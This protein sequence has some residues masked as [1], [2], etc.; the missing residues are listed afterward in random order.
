MEETMRR[1]AEALERVE[2]I[3]TDN[4]KTTQQYHQLR[5]DLSKI[6]KEALLE[7]P[8]WKNELNAEKLAAY[9]LPSMLGKLPDPSAI[10]AAGNELLNEIRAEREKIPKTVRMEGDFY[11]MA[12][13]SAFYTYLSSLIVVILSC[14][15]IC[16]YYRDQADQQTI[17]KVADELAIERN[18]YRGQINRYKVKNPTYANL[19]PAFDESRLQEAVNK[20][21]QE[22]TTP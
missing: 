4:A 9:L 2:A 6:I 17:K 22:Q 8:T 15:G 3:Q 1:I 13:R 16:L 18:F 11:G 12:S 19:F 20:L 7:R 21:K 14:V 10:T 5:S